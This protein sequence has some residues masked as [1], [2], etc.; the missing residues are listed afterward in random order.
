MSD[1]AL[2]M[3]R[4]L[5]QAIEARLLASEDYRALKALDLAIEQ[6]LAPT[7]RG[8]SPP[9]KTHWISENITNTKNKERATQKG[10]SHAD[11]AELALQKR[12][13]PATTAELVELLEKYGSMVGGNDRNTNLASSLSRDGRFRA[14]RINGKPHWW[15]K[16]RPIPSIEDFALEHGESSRGNDD[17]EDLLG[18]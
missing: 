10:M 9:L 18:S 8:S 17:L 6:A 11:A 2:Q 5:R 7:N 4:Q 16:E 15:F 14:V 13:S 1:S 3:M 12:G